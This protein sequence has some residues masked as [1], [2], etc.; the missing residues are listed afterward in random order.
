MQTC[1]EA[2]VMFYYKPLQAIILQ[3]ISLI[4]KITHVETSLSLELREGLDV[5]IALTMCSAQSWDVSILAFILYQKSYAAF[6]MVEVK[7]SS[8][9]SKNNGKET[10]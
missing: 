4:A 7:G 2:T 8:P 1:R 6:P 9:K 10:D 5:V 3:L